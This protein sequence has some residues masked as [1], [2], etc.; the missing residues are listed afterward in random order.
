[1]EMLVGRTAPVHDGTG[2]KNRRR[3]RKKPAK[4]HPSRRAAGSGRPSPC[5]IVHLSGRKGGGQSAA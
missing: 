5:V 1:M 4:D 2:Q 3:P